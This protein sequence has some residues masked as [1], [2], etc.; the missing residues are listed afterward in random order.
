MLMALEDAL[1]PSPPQPPVATDD[2][3]VAGK[4]IAFRLTN[5]LA[6]DQGPA[7]GLCPEPWRCGNDPVG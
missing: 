5:Q 1:V 3:G 2:D 4:D 6:L 7:M